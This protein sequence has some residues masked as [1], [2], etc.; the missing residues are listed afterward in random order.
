MYVCQQNIRSEDKRGGE[1]GS[2]EFTERAKRRML[3][4]SVRNSCGC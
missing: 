4:G 2:A 1:D 3:I